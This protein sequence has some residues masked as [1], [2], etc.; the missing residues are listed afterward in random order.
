VV[1]PIFLVTLL[2]VA[3]VRLDVKPAVLAVAR[4]SGRAAMVAIAAAGTW[5]LAAD[6]STIV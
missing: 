3:F 2:L 4:W 1:V 5:N 6:I